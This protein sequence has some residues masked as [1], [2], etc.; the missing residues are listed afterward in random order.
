MIQAAS[1]LKKGLWFVR[2]NTNTPGLGCVT[3]PSLCLGRSGTVVTFQHLSTGNK[4]TCKLSQVAYVSKYPEEL[5]QLYAVGKVHLEKYEELRRR[6]AQR[7]LQQLEEAVTNSFI[8]PEL[9][10]KFL[11]SFTLVRPGKPTIRFLTFQTARKVFLLIVHGLRERRELEL[12][13]LDPYQ[14]AILL[15]YQS[16]AHLAGFTDFCATNKF[17]SFHAKQ[18]QNLQDHSL[19]SRG[20]QSGASTIDSISVGATSSTS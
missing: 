6:F 2:Y 17:L 15:R 8:Q 16:E 9:K 12:S 1:F 18:Y 4:A 14:E 20:N 13:S 11:A 5:H 3:A 19:S 7:H 10:D